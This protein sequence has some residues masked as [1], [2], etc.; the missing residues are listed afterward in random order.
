MLFFQSK[1]MKIKKINYIIIAVKCCN[2]ILTL[3]F[4][5]PGRKKKKK[6]KD[7]N[8]HLIAIVNPAEP[9]YLKNRQGA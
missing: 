4:D 5:F 8:K 9:V 1:N 6:R 2:K 7:T 3:R